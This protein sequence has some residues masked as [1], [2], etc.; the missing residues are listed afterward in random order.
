MGSSDE[1]DDD[2]AD[3][4]VMVSVQIIDSELTIV[5]VNIIRKCYVLLLLNIIVMEF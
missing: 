4:D 5:P 1:S 2:S 3:D